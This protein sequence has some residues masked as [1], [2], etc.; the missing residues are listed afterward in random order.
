[1]FAF[2]DATVVLLFPF[3]PISGILSMVL[4]LRGNRLDPTTIALLKI[5]SASILASL[6]GYAWIK[7]EKMASFL[8]LLL[9]TVATAMTCLLALSSVPLSDDA[10]TFL[11]PTISWSIVL[12]LS[13]IVLILSH[14]CRHRGSMSIGMELG[15]FVSIVCLLA[16][17]WS[18]R[19]PLAKYV[20]EFQ[21]GFAHAQANGRW[22][23][24]DRQGTFVIRPQFWS[25]RGF[26][27]GL[28]E[29]SPDCGEGQKSCRGYINKEGKLIF[30]IAAEDATQFRQGLAAVKM[31]GKYGYINPNGSF[32]I[33]PRFDEAF[34]FSEELALV[35]SEGL[36][37]YI[38]TKGDQ[39]IPF[40][41]A[42]AQSFSEGLA[43]A[44]LK[45]DQKA[46]ASNFGYIDKTGKFHISP[47]YDY[48]SK[49][50][51]GVAR[52]EVAGRT[53]FIDKNGQTLFRAEFEDVND[54]SEG[55]A[56]VRKGKKFGFINQQGRVAI[57]FRFDY[58][59]DFSEER[60]SVGF[61][62]GPHGYVDKL[63]VFHVPP[64]SRFAWVR[65]LREWIQR[66][67]NVPESLSKAHPEIHRV[68][69]S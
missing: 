50:R 37:G 9:T 52:V 12:L 11:P 63:G 39:E 64:R 4:P 23:Y 41:F 40:L 60:A 21:E 33:F 57:E 65:D 17:A 35:I 42:Q 26:S 2:N 45:A 8:L 6:A 16:A 19:H 48:A 59:R 15:T 20:G 24:V 27:E 62:D 29:V 1:M 61:S 58:A 5:G 14:I 46:L 54:F 47:K 22:G 68:P 51:E 32:V 18:W 43:A 31:N 30:S 55:L 56:R 66:E 34:P 36:R 13:A 67:H 25:A 7:R 10:V 44:Q 53:V 3:F 69:T 49:F 28:A 38:N